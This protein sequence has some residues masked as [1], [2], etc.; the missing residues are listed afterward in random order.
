M[1]SG[2]RDDKNIITPFIVPNFYLHCIGRQ[3]PEI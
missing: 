1:G 2:E 3:K